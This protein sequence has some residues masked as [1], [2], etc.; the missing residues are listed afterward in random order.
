[1]GR[2]ALRITILLGVLITLVGGTGIFAVFSDRALTGPS[3]V[4][5]GEL[6]KAA[7]L[8]IAAAQPQD[9]MNSGPFNCDPFSDDLAT[10]LF[11][12]TATQGNGDDRYFCLQNAGSGDLD[13]AVTA[14]DITDLDID[15]TGDEAAFGDS[16]C[17]LEPSTLQPQAGELSPKLTIETDLY[18]CTTGAGL[19]TPGVADFSSTLADL[20]TTPTALRN[21]P[22][23]SLLCV[24]ER[25]YWHSST[26]DGYQISQSDEATWRFAFDG[27][28]PT[29]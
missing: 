8:K 7:D 26:A 11:N 15:C 1:M 28:V 24:R 10:Q 3:D 23:G 21:V 25:V 29:N 14:I 27:T 2:H 9:P 20:G 6:G 4:K 17:G 13:V 19:L 22:A 12:F 16:T 5:S 18:D